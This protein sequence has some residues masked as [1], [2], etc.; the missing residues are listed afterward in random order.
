VQLSNDTKR[1]RTANA[2][3]LVELAITTTAR[4]HNIL[5]TTE[6][7]ITVTIYVA[8]KTT[9]DVMIDIG[10]MMETEMVVAMMNKTDLDKTG[11]TT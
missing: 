10:M 4:R 1:E 3:N 7:T 6:R 5:M 9:I 11:V 2:M 8:N